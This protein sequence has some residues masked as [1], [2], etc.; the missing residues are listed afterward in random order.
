MANLRIPGEIPFA[1][2]RPSNSRLAA[3]TV[4]SFLVFIFLVCAAGYALFKY[5]PPAFF[6]TDDKEE[7]VSKEVATPEYV[8]QPIGTKSSLCVAQSQ[9]FGL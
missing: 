2:P 1:V 6:W 9:G 7:R 5:A 8:F 4:I 3:G